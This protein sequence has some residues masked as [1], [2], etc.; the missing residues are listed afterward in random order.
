[1]A[2]LCASSAFARPVTDDSPAGMT[3]QSFL[4]AASQDWENV[5][6]DWLDASGQ[7]QGGRP[8]ATAS[9]NRSSNVQLLKFDLRGLFDAWK[10]NGGWVGAIVLRA[11]AE[12]G[13]VA[14][15]ASREA[16]AVAERPQLEIQRPDGG[17]VVLVPMADARL[18]CPN[19]KSVGAAPLLNIGAGSNGVLIFDPSVIDIGKGIQRVELAMTA[20]R[21]SGRS[22]QLEVYAGRRPGGQGTTSVATGLA[23]RYAQDR[24]I[25]ADPDVLFV[26][27]FESASHTQSW[28]GDKDR[29]TTR[30]VA[31][32]DART[33]FEPLHGQALQVSIP[34]GGRRGLNSHIRWA[35]DRND[36]PEEA[37]FRYY[38]RLGEDWESRVDGGKLP[39]LAG[40][41][42]AAGWGGRKADGV[43]GWSAR[44]SFSKATQGSHAL[45]GLQAIG[46]YVYYAGMAQQ[47]GDSWGW[48]L[49]P[50][51]VLER[52]R[53]YCVEQHVRLNTPGR[54]DGQLR[55]WIDGRLVFDRNDIRF[56]DVESL[57]IESVWMNVYHGG[58]RSTAHDMTLFIDNLVV[59]KRYIGPLRP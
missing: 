9:A 11:A 52:N 16:E 4:A 25:E 34:E 58:T 59:A 47:Y 8:F 50:G 40:T 22:V 31:G 13:G 48:N 10:R 35:R 36:Q 19:Y 42:G 30:M 26:D 56:R 24:G 2:A 14:Y 46:S 49:A 54:A 32:A 41:Y 7:P 23:A 21:V 55:A 18:P 15:L 33:H 6:G 45:D 12:S 27:R 1:V 29:P 37:Y 17:R 28:L 53:W 51:G 44:G 57:R 39:G 38:L 20:A 43:S 5:G 3:C